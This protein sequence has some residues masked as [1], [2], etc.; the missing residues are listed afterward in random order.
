MYLRLW[1]AG[2]ALLSCS[3]QPLALAEDV[4]HVPPGVV[5]EW[6]FTVTAEKIYRADGLTFSLRGLESRDSTEQAF[7]LTLRTA[8]APAYH[9][10]VQTGS[11]AV[12]FVVG[13][14]DPSSSSSQLVIST[15]SG[16]AHCCA[17]RYIFL[18][19]AGGWVN[20][21][22]PAGAQDTDLTVAQDINGDGVPDFVLS[23]ERFAYAF[24]SFAESWMPPRVFFLDHG[25]LKEGSASRRYDALYRKDMAEAEVYCLRH[26]HG[27]CAGYVA[28]A[29][30]LGETGRGWNFM[31]QHICADEACADGRTFPDALA[32]F[33]VRN[34]YLS[35]EDADALPRAVSPL[36][37]AG[38]P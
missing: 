28:D 6:D 37:A 26:T 13:R 8:G 22:L 14:F 27:A 20:L 2:F 36:A 15:F 23:D 7:Q 3:V 35:R 32:Q 25:A 18:Y 38:S 34:E 1:C 17:S 30:R 21:T 5:T 11:S 33:L 29:I 9:Q 12:Q 19:Q 4:H 10:I 24:D 31:L 16:G